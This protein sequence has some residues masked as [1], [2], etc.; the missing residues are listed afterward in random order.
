MNILKNKSK[1]I[2]ILFLVATFIL[3]YFFPY[4]HD[5]WDWGSI[6]GCLRFTHFFANFN[7][8]YLG[9]LLVLL[10]TRNKLIKTL[11]VFLSLIFLILLGQKI[12]NNKNNN[13]IWLMII[14]LFLMPRKMF[15]Q[16]I[17]W[18]SGFANYFISS[19]LAFLI[20]YLNKNILNKKELNYP[21]S[22][23]FIYF[24]IGITSCLFIEHMTIYHIFLS[25]FFLIIYYIYFK[26]IN[27]SN[28]FYFFGTLIG[29]IFMFTNTLNQS[30]Y[31]SISS[32]IFKTAFDSYFNKLDYLLVIDNKILNLLFIIFILLIAY[33]Y[34]KNN[35]KYK[36]FVKCSIFIEII[37]FLYDLSLL[38]QLNFT[39]ENYVLGVFA[40]IYLLASF[41]II[42]ICL[43]KRNKLRI[44]LECFSIIIIAAPLLIVN[45]IGPRCFFPSYVFFCLIILELFNFLDYKFKET[46]LFTI[47]SIILLSY[48][49]IYGNIFYVDNKR[50][51]YLKNHL[52]DEKI[53][54]P[55]LPYTNFIH[56]G[57]PRSL[58]FTNQ[59]KL[60]YRIPKDTDLEF[61]DFDKWNELQN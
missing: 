35:A 60:Y 37:Y 56:H 18:T 6:T 27:I 17:V 55:K 25:I 46:Y 10:L 13:L 45:P 23:N 4:S 9:N 36:N 19:L 28:F 8:R 14:L 12:V 38:L 15:N 44:L 40:I 22:Y 48:L 11:I 7:G 49:Y 54:L 29:S 57:D 3:I 43:P 30:T 33:K 2:L 51:N 16:S 24:L 52:N 39:L 53:V 42:I 41:V 59:F 1:W 34:L 26:K 58:W 50:I 20:I 32:N 61:I 31:R 47:V 5:D 21:K